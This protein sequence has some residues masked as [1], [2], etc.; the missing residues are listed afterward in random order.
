MDLSQLIYWF[1]WVSRIYQNWY[2]DFSE[3]YGFVNID[4]F[5]YFLH[6]FA[7]L[8]H[9]FV[10]DDLFSRPLLL[11]WTRCWMSQSTQCPGSFVLLAMFF[12]IGYMYFWYFRGY[13]EWLLGVWEREGI[14]SF[15]KFGNR[16]RME[17]IH[18]QISG[19]GREWK[20][21]FQNIRNGKG[22]KKTNHIIRE[23]ESDTFIPGNGGEREFLLANVVFLLFSGSEQVDKERSLE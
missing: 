23:R 20:K 19:M 4:T 9:G 14:I 13:W 17:K 8:F 21:T 22:M 18:F 12:Y 11:L 10:A 3:S 6:G 7:K 15:P 1:L 16:K 2:M 5:F